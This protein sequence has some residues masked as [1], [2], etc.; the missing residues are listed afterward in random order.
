MGSSY[1][2]LAL[3][4]YEYQNLAQHRLHLIMEQLQEN[5]AKEKCINDS[6]DHIKLSVAQRVHFCDL[7]FEIRIQ[8][9]ALAIPRPRIIKINILVPP[10]RGDIITSIFQ[11]I[12]SIGI[13]S[14]TLS[15][16]FHSL[17]KD[18][19]FIQYLHDGIQQLTKSHVPCPGSDT[20]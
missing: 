19:D 13:R 8:I 5:F 15:T 6:E 9:W 16:S 11:I 2:F 4:Y 14:K 3:A 1:E 10:A 17:T 20:S 7:P 18:A 12:I